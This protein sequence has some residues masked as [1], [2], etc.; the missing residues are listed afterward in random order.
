[1]KAS[2]PT[3]EGELDGIVSQDS[4]SS[5]EYISDMVLPTLSDFG[6]NINVNLE[7]DYK[8]L[9]S[10]FKRFSRMFPETQLVNATDIETRLNNLGDEMI[11]LGFSENDIN[12]QINKE[13]QRLK[14]L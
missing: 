6:S 11:K 8:L 9:V 14:E 5:G 1:M 3:L 2:L 12:I 13:K 7:G 10:V 4:L